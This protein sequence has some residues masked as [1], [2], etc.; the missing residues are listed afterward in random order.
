MKDALSQQDDSWLS[1][2]S[3]AMD[4]QACTEL[5]DLLDRQHTARLEAMLQ[6]LQHIFNGQTAAGVTQCVLLQILLVNGASAFAKRA[7]RS[8]VAADLMQQLEIKVDAAWAASCSCNL[9]YRLTRLVTARL[10][11]TLS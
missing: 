8:E 5:F 4:K 9:Y 6:S 3:A 10:C 7:W 2:I 11:C 1:N